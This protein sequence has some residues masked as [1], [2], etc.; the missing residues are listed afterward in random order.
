MF[1]L[2][3]YMPACMMAAAPGLC[4]DTLWLRAVDEDLFVPQATAACLHTRRAVVSRHQAASTQALWACSGSCSSCVNQ[5]TGAA[6]DS[7]VDPD[8]V[9]GALLLVFT[10]L[11]TQLCFTG[12]RNAADAKASEG[13]PA[14]PSSS[15][16]SPSTSAL[17]EGE[18]LFTCQ[19]TQDEVSGAPLLLLA[20]KLGCLS[21]INCTTKQ[22]EWV[23]IW[24]GSLGCT[25]LLLV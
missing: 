16:R 5:C 21:V 1:L 8:E 15:T 19:W 23:G 6:E 25:V 18:E 12:G 7:S 22:L 2:L 14:C 17:Q 20:G 3:A 10:Q 24:T 4:A 13:S 11:D 9:S